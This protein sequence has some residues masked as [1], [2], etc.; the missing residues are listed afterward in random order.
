LQH[1]YELD[2]ILRRDAAGTTLSP[3]RKVRSKREA[4]EA[5][6][7]WG[8]LIFLIFFGGMVFYVWQGTQGASHK[9]KITQPNK[10]TSPQSDHTLT[11]SD[12]THVVHQNFSNVRKCLAKAT[13]SDEGVIKV[14]WKI[15]A[16]GTVEDVHTVSEA[17]IDGPLALCIE[18]VINH[19]RLPAHN[20][21]SVPI[22]N[23]PFKV[24]VR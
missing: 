20:L 13:P 12:V 2:A 23:Y 3:A 10:P 15:L 18:D 5:R 11:P 9:N 21:P 24:Q 6:S 1:T 7:L 8:S 19:L 14:S 4:R 16:D 17:H 22:Y